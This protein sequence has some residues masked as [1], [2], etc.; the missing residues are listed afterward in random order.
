LNTLQ[1]LEKVIAERREGFTDQSSYTA[2]LFEKGLDKILKKLGEEC[3]EVIIAA[4][5]GIKSDTLGEMAD[6]IYHLMVLMNEQG[7]ELSEVLE[8]LDERAQKTGNLKNR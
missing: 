7:I 1:N 5:N 3:S 2:Y 4:K 8:V 6:L